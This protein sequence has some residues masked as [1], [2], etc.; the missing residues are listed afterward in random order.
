MAIKNARC[1][2]VK[3]KKINVKVSDKKE[4]NELLFSDFK[5]QNWKRIPMKPVKIFL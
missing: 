2:T 1:V 3:H 5:S 4:I